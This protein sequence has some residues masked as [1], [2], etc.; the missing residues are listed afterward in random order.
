[1]IKNNYYYIEGLHKELFGIDNFAV[2]VRF[3]NGTPCMPITEQYLFYY[4]KSTTYKGL[5]K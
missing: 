2:G 4:Y 1:M 3:P 5:L